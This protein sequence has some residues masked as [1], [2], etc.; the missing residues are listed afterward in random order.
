MSLIPGLEMGERSLPNCLHS[1]LW[2]E[3]SGGAQASKQPGHFLEQRAAVCHRGKGSS[4]ELSLGR[5]RDGGRQDTA[6][7]Q[8]PASLHVLHCHVK[9]SLQDK[10]SDIKLL[11]IL[12]W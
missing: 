3:S 1:A 6:A 12:R 2:L 9:F 5:W 8:V 11:K 7:A 4:Q 10:N